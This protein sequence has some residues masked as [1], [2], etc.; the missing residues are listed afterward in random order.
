[1]KTKIESLAV[2]QF[3]AYRICRRNLKVWPTCVFAKT[4]RLAAVRSRP[5]SSCVSLSLKT[6]INDAARKEAKALNVQGDAYVQVTR[7]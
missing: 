4:E 2:V 1:M 3:F 7:K 6:G 5:R